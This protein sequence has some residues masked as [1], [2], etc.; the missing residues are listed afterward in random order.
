[1]FLPLHDEMQWHLLSSEINSSQLVFDSAYNLHTTVLL[2]SP[3]HQTQEYSTM[4]ILSAG[5]GVQLPWI[6]CFKHT[7]GP[8]K[9][10]ILNG[11]M[12]GLPAALLENWQSR[13]W[14]DQTMGLTPLLMQSTPPLTRCRVFWA[15][16]REREGE[17]E[18]T[19]ISR[20][21]KCLP[22]NAPKILWVLWNVCEVF[23]RSW[24]PGFKFFDT[25]WIQP[26]I[27]VR[28]FMQPKIKSVFHK[29]A[30]VQK[31]FDIFNIEGTLIRYTPTLYWLCRM[32][33]W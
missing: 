27:Y 5:I 20:S 18:S 14:M 2:S 33:I 26:H 16:K 7:S 11:G 12:E 21:A 25:K 3:S 28:C 19:E 10:L 23:A 4:H 9:C 6:F 8:K 29:Q 22:I 13:N 17:R 24:A 15:E 30:M 1:M 32:P 31:C